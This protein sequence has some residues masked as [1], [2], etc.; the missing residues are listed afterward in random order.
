M[1]NKAEKSMKLLL[2][3]LVGKFSDNEDVWSPC[4]SPLGS[5]R[6]GCQ[7]QLSL[8]SKL[9]TLGLIGIM[10]NGLNRLLEFVNKMWQAVNL[11]PR[12]GC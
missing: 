9:K 8:T 6:L 10:I 3:L 5:A 1:I 12:L 4:R 2:L 11:P 7:L